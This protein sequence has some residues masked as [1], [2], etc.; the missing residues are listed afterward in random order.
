MFLQL[1]VVLKDKLECGPC[2]EILIQISNTEI[3]AANE[4]VIDPKKIQSFVRAKIVSWTIVTN[5]EGCKFYQYIL[6]YDDDQLLDPQVQVGECDIVKVCCADC[7]IDYVDERFIDAATVSSLIDNGDNS[8]THDDGL[9]NLSTVSFAH[10]L[11][12][13]AADTIR[14]TRPDAT[15]DDVSIIVSADLP[16]QGDG[17]LLSPLNLL[18]STDPGNIVVLGADQGLYATETPETITTLVD[19]GNFS[20]TYS[21]EDATDTTINFSYALQTAAGT[22]TL[23]LPDTALDTQD[24]I[25]NANLPVTGDGGL[26]PLDVSISAD[27]GNQLTLGTD[28]GLFVPSVNS[29]LEVIRTAQETI[30]GNTDVSVVNGFPVMTLADGVDAPTFSC[31]VKV[32]D[33]WDPTTDPELFFRVFGQNNT[34]GDFRFS[35]ARKAVALG[36]ATTGGEDESFVFNQ[37]SPG[38]NILFETVHQNLAAASISPGDTLRITLARIGS[39]PQDDQ[40]GDLYALSCHVIFQR[41]GSGVST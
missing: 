26:T 9:A 19:N 33:D 34:D 17:S 31:H 13:P 6:E 18:I 22:V 11:S 3:L 15:T 12:K 14:L 16:L 2:S 30:H 29:P 41:T 20:F 35:I 40:T 32:P 36:E 8:F 25:V 1:P 21:S 4:G 39:H 23:V 7:T 10:T 38:A 27:A 28:S 37:A 5:K 24:L